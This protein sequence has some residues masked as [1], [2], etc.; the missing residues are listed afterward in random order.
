MSSQA[1]DSDFAKKQYE[2]ILKEAAQYA[3]KDIETKKAFVL[4]LKEK[5]TVMF[6]VEK[7]DLHE[8][9]L[10]MWNELIRYSFTYHKGEFYKLFST[11]EKGNYTESTVP[12]FE[13]TCDFAEDLGNGISKCNCGRIDI[14]GVEYE[15]SLAVTDVVEDDF[16]KDQ[17]EQK[18]QALDNTTC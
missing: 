10:Y 5:A 4:R 8:L 7:R 1:S 3:Q 16:V 13:H 17:K 18:K 9:A 2:A 12:N 11:D 14:E 15:I 6:E